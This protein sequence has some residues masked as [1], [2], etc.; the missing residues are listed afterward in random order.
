[1]RIFL[2]KTGGLGDNYGL[3]SYINGIVDAAK[4]NSEKF[5]FIVIEFNLTS[6][7]ENIK[8]IK[9][10]NITVC[11][12]PV[13]YH[14]INMYSDSLFPSS[15]CTVLQD[16]YNLTRNDIFHFNSSMHYLLAKKIQE[17]TGGA[18]I[19]TVHILLWKTIYKN[20]DQFLNEYKNKV[21]KNKLIAIHNEKDICK[22]SKSIICMNS[23]TK[24]YLSNVYK[25]NNNKIKKIP[26]GLLIK[27]NDPRLERPLDLVKSELGF[28]NDKIILFVGRIDPEK[29][30][31]DLIKAFRKVVSRCKGIRLIVVGDGAISQALTLCKG[32]WSKVLF[33][34]YVNDKLQLLDLY[35]VA[36]LMVLPS[37]HEQSSFTFLEAIKNKK[38]L[39]ISDI[40]AFEKLDSNSCIKIGFVEDKKNDTKVINNRQLEKAMVKLITKPELAE[41]LAQ[42][43]F[44]TFETEFNLHSLFKSLITVYKRN[45]L[46]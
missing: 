29:G 12:I 41:S 6:K 42:Q 39:I 2:F 22:I 1:M 26:N 5:E 36:D 43:A 34:G 4:V 14:S 45:K 21:H 37:Y 38:P 15:I 28:A 23:E 20:E 8:S 19:Y 11:K 10:N 31:F 44:M 32:I 35:R 9:R 7:I 46:T 33:T 16:R 17:E 40:P 27:E 25:V 18:I 30:V 24:E 13:A 3:G